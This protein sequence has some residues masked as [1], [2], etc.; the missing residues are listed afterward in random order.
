MESFKDRLMD[1]RLAIGFSQ[2]QLAQA[3]N[4]SAAQISRYESGDAI[5][6]PG[7][8]KRLAEHL[9]V[10]TKWLVSGPPHRRIRAATSDTLPILGEGG[11]PPEIMQR[12]LD[13]AEANNRTLSEQIEAVIEKSYG[14]DRDYLLDEE[15]QER[16]E[17]RLARTK[18]NV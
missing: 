8:A 17:K 2:R 13:D 1:A 15:A 9:G 7:V 11:L 3:V 10:T 14:V 16:R 12:L 6:R 4:V 5:P 18:K